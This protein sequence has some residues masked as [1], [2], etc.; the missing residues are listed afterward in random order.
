MIDMDVMKQ[1]KI[2]KKAEHWFFMV[3]IPLIKCYVV[4]CF[5]KTVYYIHQ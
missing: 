3:F 4:C 1:I 2:L 5:S